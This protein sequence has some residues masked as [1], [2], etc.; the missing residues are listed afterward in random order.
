MNLRPFYSL[1]LIGIAA[2]QA[3]CV[4]VCNNPACERSL[5]LLGWCSTSNKCLVNGQVITACEEGSNCPFDRILPGTHYEVP[6]DKLWPELKT[7][8]D[9][10]FQWKRDFKDESNVVVFLDG[11]QA[12][13]DMC[14][15]K[16]A[17]NFFSV[18]CPN[19]PRSITRLEFDF[20]PPKAGVTENIAMSIGVEDS[21]CLDAYYDECE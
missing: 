6:L 13:E 21:E 4:D 5:N 12:M 3:D 17:A 10:G 2:M 15:R 7:R 11:V 8:N 14:Q 20:I 19:L 1:G 18:T 9:F 16:P